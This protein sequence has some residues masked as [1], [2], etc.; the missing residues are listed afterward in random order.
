[1]HAADQ[2]VARHAFKR[3]IRFEVSARTVLVDL[4][5]IS[6]AEL[7]VERLEVATDFLPRLLRTNRSVR[8]R[9]STGSVGRD[10]DVVVNFRHT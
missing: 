3:H 6:I 7:R 5:G 10:E 1:V 9:D 4:G 8:F 2:D